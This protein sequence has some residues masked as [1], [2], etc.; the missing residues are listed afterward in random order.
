MR[1]VKPTL[2]LP[3]ACLLFGFD[4]ARACVC[5]GEKLSDK[6][7]V[8]RAHAYS[9][10]VFSG[11]VIEVVRRGK[12]LPVVVRFRVEES[13][14]DSGEPEAVVLTGASGADCGLDFRVGEKYLVYASSSDGTSLW[15]QSCTRTRTLAG[16]GKDLKLL[17]KGKAPRRVHVQ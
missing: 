11:E 12:I 3:L 13:W 8:A 9:F 1:R 14:K 7:A 15:A 2:I 6:E 5:K 16:A 4:V 17:G 10:A